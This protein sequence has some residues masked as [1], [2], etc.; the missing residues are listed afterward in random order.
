MDIH[1]C[2]NTP[3][4]VYY[5][6]EFLQVI[7]DHLS[8]L[9]LTAAV[10]PV[11]VSQLQGMKYEGDFYGLLADNN[12]EKKYHH[13]VLRL[14]GYVSS[15]DYSGDIDYFLLPDFNEVEEIKSLHMTTVR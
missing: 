12:V 9:R 3:E 7:E 2:T 6:Q 8:Y 5:S 13:V 1:A 14:N 11:A 15:A 4:D 10:S